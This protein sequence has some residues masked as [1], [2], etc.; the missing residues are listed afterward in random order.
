MKKIFY[1]IF[2][3]AS[4]VFASCG[5]GNGADN[6]DAAVNAVTANEGAAK[7][8][9]I[10]TQEDI[11][12]N[13]LTPEQY[14][15]LGVC[16]LYVSNSSEEEMA[17]IKGLYKSFDKFGESLSDEQLQAARQAAMSLVVP[18]QTVPQDS[19]GAEEVSDSA[20]VCD[21]VAADSAAAKEA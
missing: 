16:L 21:S 10:L 17:K 2:L 11:D 1:S 19:V 5:G 9:E 18:A 6:I 4:F 8:V 20:A 14:G 13:N 3:L 7:V 15:K 12:F